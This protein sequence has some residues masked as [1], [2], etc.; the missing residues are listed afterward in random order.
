MSTL[1]LDKMFAPQSV[2]VIGA[3]TKD[4]SLGAI[5]ARN[6]IESFKGPVR[7][8][9]PT[10]DTI[11]G[12]PAV[13]SIADL[14]SAADLAI[15]ATPPDTVAPI[16]AELGQQG[17]QAT[18]VI[19]AGFGEG[20]DAVG[21][22]RKQALLNAAQPNNV[23]IV[24]PNCLGI[25]LPHAGLNAS[26]SHIMPK[27]GDL[28]FV[29]QSGALV[30]AMVDWAAPRDIGFSA[31]VS[32]G[33]KADVDFSDMMRFLGEDPNTRA[34]LL[35]VEAIKHPD[36]FMEAARETAQTKPVIVIK[37][38][39]HDAAAKAA[40]SHTGALA[41]SDRAYDA[42]FRRSGLV[43][44]DTLEELFDVAELLT[45][46][47]AIT[48][49]RLAIVTNGG[50]FGVLGVDELM[51]SHGD[52]AELS[53]ETLAQLDSVLPATW[54]RGNPVDI[55]GDAPAERYRSAVTAVLD[56]PRVDA[57]MV[58]N[59]PTALNDS[60]E[61][62]EAVL[63]VTQSSPKPVISVWA[64]D[65]AGAQARTLFQKNKVPAFAAP[66]AAVGAFMHLVQHRKQIQAL[67]AE[68]QQRLEGVVDK[69]AVASIFDGA[70][71]EGRSM[72][73]EHEAKAVFASYGI[74]VNQTHV[75]TSPE[76]AAQ[77]AALID[78][79]VALKILSPDVVHKSDHGGVLLDLHGPEAVRKGAEQILERIGAAFPDARIDGL[80]VQEMVRRPGAYELIAGAAVDPTFGHV[81]MFGHG[82]TAVEAI[83][84]VAM[85]L[86]PLTRPLAR[87]MMERTLIY[88]RL[89]GYRAEPP[90]D[91][92]AVED[93]LLSLSRLLEDFPDIRELDINPMLSD[94]KGLIAIDGRMGIAA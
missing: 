71:A 78:G 74:P 56:D 61:L 46:Q 8:V 75:V 50:G 47:N 93:V 33:D 82:G 34:I 27:A 19:T 18:V 39:R 92:T 84:D 64:G 24:G 1:N 38:G 11:E 57:V 9:H 76:H 66:E 13:P 35:Y 12:R 83:G 49:G 89:K 26:F 53:P 81:L 6:I 69:E 72:L 42:A 41:G 52:L 23:R 32:M 87:N 14:E 54:S 37:S 60:T 43:R 59:C 68:E 86:V 21:S 55:I 90:V 30:T 28:A 63:D 2:V 91:L 62:A 45:G 51:N 65:I 67:D 73:M 20:T 48:G 85:D 15:I 70:R 22:A 25:I 4:G 16:V 58:M 88:R 17:T 80:V 77:Q 29:S 79:P 94:P 31:I 3:S 40:A 44:V 36:K 5:L 7:F 10:A